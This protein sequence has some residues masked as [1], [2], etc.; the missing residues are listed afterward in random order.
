MEIRNV[1]KTDLDSLMT[2]EREGFTEGEAATKQAMLE[3]IHLIADTF[4]VAEKGGVVLGYINGPVIDNPFITDD[5]F[6]RIT[7]NPSRGGYQAILGVAVSEQARR[8]GIAASLFH[9]IERL[10]KENGRE[11]VTLTCKEELISFYEKLGY[12]HCGRSNSVHGG[13]AWYNLIKRM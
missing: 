4:L 12:V 1:R 2:I 10:A 6:E 5:L 9:E 3:R 13:V 7:T 8:Q 11:G